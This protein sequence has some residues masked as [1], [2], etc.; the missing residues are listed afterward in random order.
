MDLTPVQRRDL[1]TQHLDDAALHWWRAIKV[2]LDL[3]TF[4]YEEFVARFREKFVPSAERDRLCSLFLNLK[5]NGRPVT[6]YIN[7]FN[8]LGRYAHHMVD[9]EEKK[10]P[11][12]LIT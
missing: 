1:V 8:E 11:I 2:A 9:T 3:T 5:Q 10:G 6:E 7:R 4:T 12:S